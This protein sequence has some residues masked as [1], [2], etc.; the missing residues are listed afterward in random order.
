MA[1]RDLGMQRIK[2]EEGDTYG[3]GDR[4]LNE[5]RRGFDRS[6]GKDDDPVL[7]FIPSVGIDYDVI[8]TELRHYLG[9]DATLTRGSH[10][11][12]GRPGYY[13]RA[14]LVPPIPMISELKM[15]TSRWREEMR[16]VTNR[17]YS[18]SQTHALRQRSG[19]TGRDVT[20]QDQRQHERIDS[21]ASFQVT[22]SRHK[23]NSTTPSVLNDPYSQLSADKS[24]R[25]PRPQRISTLISAAIG[26]H[27][28]NRILPD[29]E[30]L[31]KEESQ[32]IANGLSNLSLFSSPTYRQTIAQ[33]R[34]SV[35]LTPSSRDQPTYTRR[36]VEMAVSRHFKDVG[37]TTILRSEFD[38][39]IDGAMRKIQQQQF[40]KAHPSGRRD[41]FN[42]DS[43]DISGLR[44]MSSVG[45]FSL[46]L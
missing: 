31:Q 28:S 26:N 6:E 39:A 3:D 36:D 40:E 5:R 19:P 30:R 32:D 24:M 44:C 42:L 33:N 34:E 17:D 23:T 12:N 21:K 7:C 25:H 22:Q 37:R 20:H 41:S 46:P 9:Q 14:Y 4:D 16:S 11:K 8:T 15:D 45:F 18:S 13:I 35:E 43:I 10:P 2:G 1:S 38:R 29:S 27:D